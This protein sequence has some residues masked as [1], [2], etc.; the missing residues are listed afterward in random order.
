MERFPVEESDLPVLL[1]DDVDFRKKWKPSRKPPS[2]KK[3]LVLKLAF[4]Q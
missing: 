2:W 4:L 3:P 1:P